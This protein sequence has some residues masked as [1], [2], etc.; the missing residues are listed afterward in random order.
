VIETQ[1]LLLE[2]QILK[3]ELRQV[4]ETS[5]SEIT[6]LKYQLDQLKR[7]G[8][9]AKSERFLS[10][11]NAGQL[12]LP[13]DD[14]NPPVVEKEETVTVEAHDRKKKK[15]NHPIRKPFPVDLPRE[16]EKIY[17]AG[18]DENSEEKLIG[19]EVTE[20]LEEIPGKFYVRQIIRYK[21]A[22]KETGGGVIGELPSRV[23]EKGMFGESLLTRIIIDSIISNQHSAHNNQ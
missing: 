5:Q 15:K 3:Q 14:E 10:M 11:L 12:A 6:Y 1:D 8:F 4:K 13:I 2:N 16:V 21:F 9:G 20:I 7:R 23:N 19:E 18:F 17:P 22:N